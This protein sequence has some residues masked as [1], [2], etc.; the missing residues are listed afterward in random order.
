MSHIHLLHLPAP[1]CSSMA[2]QILSVNSDQLQP[3]L[4]CEAGKEFTA[5]NMVVLNRWLY[6][7]TWER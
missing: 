6:T 4:N 7:P 3:L 5:E 1:S 2:R